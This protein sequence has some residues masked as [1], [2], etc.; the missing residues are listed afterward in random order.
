MR[1][2][3]KGTLTYF[4]VCLLYLVKYIVYMYIISDNGMTVSDEFPQ[5]L[6]VRVM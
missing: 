4:L 3:V 2:A 1:S 5:L 6:F